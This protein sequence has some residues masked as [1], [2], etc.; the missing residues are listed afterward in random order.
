M[1]EVDEDR[2][3]TRFGLELEICWNYG[4]EG[5]LLYPFPETFITLSFMEKFKYYLFNV[6]LNPTNPGLRIMKGLSPEY[7]GSEIG[8]LYMDDNDILHRAILDLN[9]PGTIEEPNYI[10]IGSKYDSRFAHYTIPIFTEDISLVCGDAPSRLKK[11]YAPENNALVPAMSMG[12]EC[13]TPV[14]KIEGRVTED[15]V[16]F[17]SQ[18][19]LGFFGLYSPKCFFTN[20][21]T[22]FHVN[23]SLGDSNNQTIRLNCESF[24]RFF[25]PEYMRYEKRMYS[26]VRQQLRKGQNYSSWAERLS[27]VQA[28]IPNLPDEDERAN[29]EHS[30]FLLQTKHWAVLLKTNSVF[31]FRLFGSN[32]DFRVL[33]D[34]AYQACHLLNHIFD[35]YMKKKSQGLLG[36]AQTRR[37]LRRRLRRTRRLRVN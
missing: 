20:Y 28:A 15:K 10:T 6:L 2:R 13:I 1:G 27:N 23:V 18:L 33:C 36:G 34:Y 24:R 5:C 11:K 21:T 35:R 30:L 37:R 3:I 8:I 26:K 25:V 7:G 32:T 12:I 4:E 17:F 16:Y 31:E 29:Q 22:G 9:N 14:L 19:Y